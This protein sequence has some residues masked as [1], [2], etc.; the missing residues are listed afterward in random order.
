MHLE[1]I[2]FKTFLSDRCG[3]AWGLYIIKIP[4][5]VQ[6]ENISVNFK[7]M[8]DFHCNIEPSMRI[9]I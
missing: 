5:K 9:T 6:Y 1:I 3:G 2:A 4:G 7:S 8:V